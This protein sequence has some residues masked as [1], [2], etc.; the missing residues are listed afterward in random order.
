MKV[1]KIVFPLL[2]II[3]FLIGGYF[4]LVK[5]GDFEKTSHT[6]MNKEALKK[7]SSLYIGYFINW[8][9]IGSPTIEKIEFFKEDGSLLAKREDEIVITPFIDKKKEIG[10]MYEEDLIKE[11]YMDNLLD[12]KGY[13]VKDELNLVLKVE[14]GESIDFQDIG[15][16]RIMYR[17]LGLTE[18]QE[19]SFDDG[20]VTGE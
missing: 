5:E 14:I 8:N 9:G 16:I 4:Y 19:I 17:K 11:G 15:K 1:I 20:I 6:S 10:T 2:V 18:Y 13:K 12:V 3:S 7:N